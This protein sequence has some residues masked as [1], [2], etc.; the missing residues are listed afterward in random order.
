M[1]NHKV[2]NKVSAPLNI[3]NRR[4]VQN[5]LKNLKEGKST[6]LSKVTSGY[7]FHHVSADEM[8]ILNEIEDTLSGIVADPF[9]RSDF[10]LVDGKVVFGELTFTPAAGLDT[11]KLEYTDRLLGDLINLSK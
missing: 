7:H 10:Y 3:K 1:V 8:E 4:D 2:Y 5:F 9:V 6:P 11:G